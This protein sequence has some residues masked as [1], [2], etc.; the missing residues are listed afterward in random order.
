MKNKSAKKIN[1]E[2]AIRANI[3]VAKKA[4]E[5]MIKTWNIWKKATKIETKMDCLSSYIAALTVCLVYLE[6]YLK[7]LYPNENR[8]PLKV[9]RDIHS[10]LSDMDVIDKVN[11]KLLK[12]AIRDIDQLRR[13]AA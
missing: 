6:N 8:V 3:D 7:H 1:K 12:K 13:D 2:T 10:I 4:V 5:M 11:S 9:H